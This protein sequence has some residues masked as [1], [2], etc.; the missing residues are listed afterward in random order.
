MVS[1]EGHNQ[2]PMPLQRQKGPSELNQS[3]GDKDMRRYDGNSGRRYSGQQNQRSSSQFKRWDRDQVM[4]ALRNRLKEALPKILSSHFTEFDITIQVVY[5]SATGLA[6]NESDVD[7]CIVMNE[8]EKKSTPEEEKLKD[9]EIYEPLVSL[10][11][12]K[13]E[14]EKTEDKDK[15]KDSKRQTTDETDLYN[16]NCESLATNSSNGK[17][18]PSIPILKKIKE[19]LEDYRFVTEIQLLLAKVPILKFNDRISGIEVTLN[20]NKLVKLIA[21]SHRAARKHAPVFPMPNTSFNRQII[22]DLLNNS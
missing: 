10:S 9:T 19:G 21:K 12:T 6:N 4:L 17:N 7:I 8:I 14:V 16:E 11:D 1:Q 20:V 5:C 22:F 18:D 3:M 13:T 2:S 15:E